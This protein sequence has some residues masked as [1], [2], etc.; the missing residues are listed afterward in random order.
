MSRE[1]LTR[2][3]LWFSVFGWGI[4]LGAKLFDLIVLA[5][6]WGAAPPASLAL[7]P[8]GPHYPLNPGDFFQP[9]SALMVVG[10]LGA[11][12]SGWKTPLQYRIWLWMP[13]IS[14]LIIWVFT[15]TVFWPMIRELYGAGSGKVVKSE[16]ELIL[17]VR[18][19]MIWD[20]LRVALIAL[21]FLASVRALS[22]PFPRRDR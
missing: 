3:F 16:A 14:F 18:R 7:M 8:Y 15:P 5:S 10:I 21:G 12:I 22:T 1:Q 2:G 6:A 19:W 17:L 20:W 4:G 9:L 13:V 11:L